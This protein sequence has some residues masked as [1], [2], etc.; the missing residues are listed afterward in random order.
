MLR[1]EGWEIVRQSGSH[2]VWRSPA[3]RV[4][5]VAGK[6]SDTVPAGTL[7]A[8]RRVTGLDDLP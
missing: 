2:Q 8:M 5:T 3:G 1:N 6:D 4:V 7:S